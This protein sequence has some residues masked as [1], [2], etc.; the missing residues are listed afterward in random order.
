MSFIGEHPILC[1]PASLSFLSPDFFS[2]RA[3]ALD[4]SSFEPFDL[5]E[6]QPAGDKSVQ[7]LLP[8][9]LA[10]H[11]HTRRPMMQHDARRGLVDVLA[12]VSTGTHERFVDLRLFHAQLRHAQRHLGFFVGRD[13]KR[14]HAAKLIRT[15][16]NGKEERLTTIRKLSL[17]NFRGAGEMMFLD[18]ALGHDVQLTPSRDLQVV[19]EQTSMATPPHC[20]GAHKGNPFVFGDAHQALD[21]IEE[22]LCYSE[23]EPCNFDR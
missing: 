16:R 15:A 23:F 1:A 8:A 12:P 10:L 14:T 19:P 21:S 13:C 20:L 18:F 11:L 9:R 5:V 22:D 7:S 17:D 3:L 6:Q 2:F 4:E